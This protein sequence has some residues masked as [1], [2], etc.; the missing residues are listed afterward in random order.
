LC[1]AFYRWSAIIRAAHMSSGH[2][3]EIQMRKIALL[4][5]A[6]A[7]FAA[8]AWPASAQQ[9]VVG[10]WNSGCYRLGDTGYHWYDFCLGP[11]IAYPHK[12]VCDHG[13]CTYQW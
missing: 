2:F 1:F 8:T 7:T 13:N 6:A 4:V 11:N 5:V 10:G 3:R 12:R 9:V